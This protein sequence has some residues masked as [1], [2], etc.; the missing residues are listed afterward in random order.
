MHF[1]KRPRSFLAV[2]ML[3]RVLWQHDSILQ[4]FGT[5]YYIWLLSVVR[6]LDLVTSRL[7]IEEGTSVFL[8]PSKREVEIKSGTILCKRQWSF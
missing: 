5:S 4:V 2:T 6:A 3:T 1:K 8:S 7:A